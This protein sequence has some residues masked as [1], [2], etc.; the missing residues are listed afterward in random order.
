[1]QRRKIIANQWFSVERRFGLGWRQLRNWS[2]NAAW[3]SAEET[4]RLEALT[5][6]LSA[7]R[8]TRERA[9]Q[10]CLNRIRE[11]DPSIHAWVQVLPQKPTGNGNLSEIPFGVKDIIETRSLSTEYPPLGPDKHQR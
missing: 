9:L 4:P 1:V 3:S 8:K 2:L 10:P 7:S 6:W 5:Q 11:M